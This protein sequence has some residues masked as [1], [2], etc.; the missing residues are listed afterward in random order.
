VEAKRRV[1]GV[2]SERHGEE[3]VSAVTQDAVVS[4]FS[5]ILN[6]LTLALAAIAGVSLAVAGLGVM[7]VMLVTVAERT[8]EEGLP[9]AVGA[10]RRQILG[11]FLAEAGVRP[12]LL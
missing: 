10:G 8:G 11:V 7:N 12:A 1:V 6:A 9:R 4:S 5:K 3:D 2:L